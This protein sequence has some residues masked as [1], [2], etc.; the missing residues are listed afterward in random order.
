MK[1]PALIL[2]AT[3]GLAAAAPAYDSSEFRFRK[4][5][6][7]GPARA[8]AVVAIPLDAD[9]FDATR[10]GYPDIRLAT[11]AGGEASFAI[12]RATVS[13]YAPVREP[14]AT[15][16]IALRELPGNR[17]EVT[18][19]LEPKQPPATGLTIHTPLRDYEHAVQVDGSTDGRSW[20]PLAAGAVIFDYARFMDVRS[21]EVAIPTNTFRHYRVVISDVTEEQSSALMQ[22][23]RERREHGGDAE[24]RTTHV[25]KRPFRIDRVLFWREVPRLVERSDARQ[26]W[27]VAGFSV[28]NDAKSR[29]TTVHIRTRREP[30]TSF[31]LETASRNFVRAAAVQIPSADRGR[32][33][34]R[35]IASANLSRLSILSGQPDDRTIRFEEQREPE[36][37]IVIRNAD[38]EPLEITG[39]EAEGSR[40]RLLLI[41][42]PGAR[43]HLLYGSTSAANP[44][45][46]AAQVLSSP[47]ASPRAE[48]SLGPEE[49]NTGFR[50]PG[51]IRW[52]RTW[53]SG[54]VFGGALAL[55]VAVLAFGIYRAVRRID[56]LPP[57]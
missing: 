6:D 40:Y 20:A 19:E 9:V 21:P 49:P 2:A 41:A 18:F 36:Y 48:W 38:S 34:W 31:S 57:E 12:E 32:P 5:V 11:D 39:I 4:A 53:N 7:G 15:R 56:Q 47:G 14:I 17:I 24:I 37:R 29:T 28:T 46:D 3:L 55:M 27:P 22:L 50:D 33:A 44:E 1:T 51:G 30:L 8:D 13:R 26:I 10:P 23:T 35:D 42:A 16:L 52:W 54:P 43:Y 25:E 45:Y